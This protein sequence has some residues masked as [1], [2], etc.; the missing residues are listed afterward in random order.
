MARGC[1]PRKALKVNVIVLVLNEVVLG[2]RRGGSCD[3]G[4]CDWG[5]CGL[6]GVV[7]R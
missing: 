5:E 6:G 7:E 3:W 1:G 2:S 4:E